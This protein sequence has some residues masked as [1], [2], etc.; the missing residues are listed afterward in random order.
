METRVR[1]EGVTGAGGGGSKVG[2]AG[3]KRA[4]NVEASLLPVAWSDSRKP[5]SGE[6]TRKPDT[7]RRELEVLICVEA[8]SPAGTSSPEWHLK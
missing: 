4:W 7:S 6:K 1:V 3:S 5:T 8:S 2:A